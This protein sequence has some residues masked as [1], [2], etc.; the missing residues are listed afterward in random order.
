MTRTVLG[1]LGKRL[2]KSDEVLVEAT[3]NAMAVVRVLSPFLARVI[4]CV[5][6]T[7]QEDSPPWSRRRRCAPL[8]LLAL[9]LLSRSPAG[10]LVR[11][12]ARVA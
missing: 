4:I 12:R 11:R 9:G 5:S 8:D 6:I 2:Q 7:G 1:G 10:S 3:G